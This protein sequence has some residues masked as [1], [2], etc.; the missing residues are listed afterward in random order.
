[1]GLWNVFGIADSAEIVILEKIHGCCSCGCVIFGLLYG[2]GDAGPAR[3]M[4]RNKYA[5]SDGCQPYGG[6]RAEKGRQ[7]IAKR[8]DNGRQVPHLVGFNPAKSGC[9]VARTRLAWMGG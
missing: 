3:R 7:L 1:M 6:K 5:F 8:I 9:K 2:P 4:Q